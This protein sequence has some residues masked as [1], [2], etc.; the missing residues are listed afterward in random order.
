MAEVSGESHLFV[1][2]IVPRHALLLSLDMFTRLG[3]MQ[4]SRWWFLLAFNL[5]LPACALDTAAKTSTNGRHTALDCH[6]TISLPS[7]C[8]Y[9]LHCLFYCGIHDMSHSQPQNS[10]CHDL[11]HI[12]THTQYKHTLHTFAVPLAS[13]SAATGVPCIVSKR[14][15]EET[16]SRADA[17]LT[18]AQKDRDDGD[19]PAPKRLKL[20]GDDT[21]ACDLSTVT[22]LE[23]GTAVP[24]SLHQTASRS[25][26]PP[27][28]ST[29]A[30][31]S[32]PMSASSVAETAAA[33]LVL[34]EP[35]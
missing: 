35:K 5:L 13:A 29:H 8:Y 24:T 15:A 20:D 1:W 9:C 23:S 17:H 2:P 26:V 31:A 12:H 22:E 4:G 30:A 32:A 33:A 25:S 16:S 7:K 28:I 21:P 19:G 14:S 27:P 10:H 6:H 11:T 3:S 18:P 34:E